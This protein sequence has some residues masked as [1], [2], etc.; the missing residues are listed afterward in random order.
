MIKGGC[1]FL[2]NNSKPDLPIEEP[3]RLSRIEIATEAGEST[4]TE[5]HKP[6]CAGVPVQPALVFFKCAD[7][8]A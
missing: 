7:T 4:A 8:E 1:L 5:G 2:G 3:S 6:S